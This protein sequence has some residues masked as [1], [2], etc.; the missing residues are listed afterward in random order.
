MT[1]KTSLRPAV[2]NRLPYHKGKPVYH[3]PQDGSPIL[4]KGGPRESLNRGIGET[5]K[6]NGKSVRNN[7]DFRVNEYDSVRNALLAFEPREASDNYYQVRKLVLTFNHGESRRDYHRLGQ[8]RIA[9]YQTLEDCNLCYFCKK[10]IKVKRARIEHIETNIDTSFF[11]EE[12]SPDEGL[13]KRRDGGVKIQSAN[14]KQLRGIRYRPDR[15]ELNT[16]YGDITSHFEYVPIKDL[17]GKIRKYKFVFIDGSGRN[18]QLRK[19]GAGRHYF[20]N[21][22]PDGTEE[23]IIPHQSYRR[24]DKK[25]KCGGRKK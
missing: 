2:L 13:N 15:K 7:K 8:Y 14:G 20:V 21:V 10:P 1:I 16:T 23:K 18:I 9:Y 22:L 11:A 4:L 24:Y 5:C 25:C 6:I 17:D 19:L 3:R 12:K